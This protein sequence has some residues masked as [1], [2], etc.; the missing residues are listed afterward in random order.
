MY[1]KNRLLF[2][3]AIAVFASTLLF[4]VYTESPTV[5]PLEQSEETIQMRL[6]Y[7]APLGSTAEQVE[8]MILGHGWEM[9][10]PLANRGF[11]D[12]R[13]KPAR[14]VGAKHLRASLGDYYDFWKV[15][16]TVF[17]GFDQDERLIDVWVWKTSDAL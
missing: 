11:Y 7:E 12:Q 6:L 14:D 4:F 8:A 15:N 17:W 2:L 3:S 10:Y 13:V 5:D 1:R 16:V 9:M